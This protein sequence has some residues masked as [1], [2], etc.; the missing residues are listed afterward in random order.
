MLDRWRRLVKGLLIRHAVMSKYATQPEDSPRL[1][2]GASS[3]AA[4]GKEGKQEV[5]EKE[6]E[7]PVGKEVDSIRTR[8][9]AS[10]LTEA[11]AAL[12]TALAQADAPPQPDP[13]KHSKT[14]AASNKKKKKQI[15]AEE[16]EEEE[17]E[18]TTNTPKPKRTSKPQAPSQLIDLD[19]ELDR[20][21]AH[22]AQRGA[23]AEEVTLVSEGKAKP[24]ERGKR[25]GK[26]ISL[27]SP[28]FSPSH[29][30]GSA[31]TTNTRVS[32]LAKFAPPSAL[33]TPELPSSFSTPSSSPSFSSPS[34]SSAPFSLSSSSTPAK[35]RSA[36]G[37]HQHA[38]PDELMCVDPVSGERRKRCACGFSIHYEEI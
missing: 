32:P 6:E 34:V 25:G 20:V 28:F 11:P 4:T 16:S 38:F 33:S 1:S 18:E 13:A 26:A 8:T 10:E 21:V 31:S 3:A 37:F 15:I 12:S 24:R 19:A 27:T 17:E 29:G 35:K 22:D 7:E 36:G 2:A 30:P 23:Q 9:D 14:A 5:V